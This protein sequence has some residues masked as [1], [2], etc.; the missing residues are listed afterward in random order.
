MNVYFE[1]YE[2]GWIFDG[3][4]ITRD[5][6]NNPIQLFMIFDIYFDELSKKKKITPQPIHTY[7]F[8]SRGFSSDI[9][10]YSMIQNFFND[11]KP[12]KYSE[13]SEMIR[14]GMKEHHFGESFK[15]GC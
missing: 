8:I 3:E 13:D 11:M 10:R 14:I 6:E 9:S 15:N 2:N 5:K 7:P 1:N 12:I 4:Y